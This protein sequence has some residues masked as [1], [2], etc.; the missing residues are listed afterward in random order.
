[1]GRTCD[2]SF[3]YSKSSYNLKT[4]Y[5]CFSF[6]PNKV[7]AISNL[8]FAAV[9]VPDVYL[10]RCSVDNVFVYDVR[11]EQELPLALV[12]VVAALTTIRFF[13]CVAVAALAI[14]LAVIHAMA[15]NVREALGLKPA[16]SY[17]CSVSASQICY[18]LLTGIH[19]SFLLEMGHSATGTAPFVTVL[20]ARGLDSSTFRHR[21][22]RLGQSSATSRL[23][24]PPY[25]KTWYTTQ[26]HYYA[27]PYVVASLRNRKE[28]WHSALRENLSK[29]AEVSGI[30]ITFD[31]KTTRPRLSVTVH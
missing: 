22:D 29:A 5:V 1:M 19:P 13:V 6:P 23:T 18:C 3:P 17:A 31:N 7:K 25:D 15:H 14:V 12:V 9:S 24:L 16:V 11:K 21:C 20:I 4:F 30:D 27:A 28:S 26:K 2:P 10:A 8:V